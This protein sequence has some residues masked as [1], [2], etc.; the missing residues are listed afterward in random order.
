MLAI[1]FF[2]LTYLVLFALAIGLT[3]LAPY[4]IIL[5]IGSIGLNY[6][7]GALVLGSFAMGLLVLYFLIKFLFKKHTTDLSHLTEITRED[8]PELFSFIGE[9]VREAGTNFPKKIYLSNDVNAAVFYD[10]SFWSMFFPVRKNLQIGVGLINTVT[11]LELKAILAHEFGHFSQRSMKLGSYVYNTNQVIYNMLYDNQSYQQVLQTWANISNVLYFFVIMAVKIVQVIQAVLKENY[12]LLNISY[13]GLSREMEFHADAVAAQVAGSQPLVT[14]LMRME[15]ADTSFQSV[16]DYYNQRMNKSVI[17]KNIYSQQSLVLG[18]LAE[19]GGLPL[20]HG[21]PHITEEVAGKYRKSKIVIKDQ[22]ASHPSTIDRV[23]ALNRL[24][25]HREDEDGTPANSLLKDVQALQE[26][27]TA[28]IFKSVP[29]PENIIM[30]TDERFA[31][32]Y[33]EA[34]HAGSFPAIFNGYFDQW[35][36]IVHKEVDLN[37]HMGALTFDSLFSEEQCEIVY[38]LRTNEGDKQVLSQLA[39]EG[40]EIKTF[41]YD[42]TRYK[43]SEAAQL[44]EQVEAEE[45]LLKEKATSNDKCIYQYFRQL[46]ADKGEL[47]KFND[48]YAIY[49]EA[50]EKYAERI[51]YYNALGESIGFMHEDTSYDEIKTKLKFVATAENKIKAEIRKMMDYPPYRQAFTEDVRENFNNYL[52]QDWE[53]FR[54]NNYVEASLTMLRTIMQTYPIVVGRSYFFTKKALLDNMASLQTAEVTA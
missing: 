44:V 8:H 50:D 38:T 14:S 32:N 4:T 24:N 15:L 17:T 23:D 40:H 51:G 33:R 9:I 29:L 54:L 39:A 34:E 53:Y 41:D 13:M 49:A 43:A 35:N 25:I 31:A 36:P 6:F 21:L 37:N 48:L 30:E 47:E 22:W 12:K 26:R 16:I 42:G 11:R 20:Q 10:S 7:T 1:L 27:L 28:N 2:I 5:L 18:I 45:Q 52:S 46:A 3:I 19:T